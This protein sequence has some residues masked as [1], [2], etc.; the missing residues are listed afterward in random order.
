MGKTVTA[1][2]YRAT[3]VVHDELVEAVK[4]ATDDASVADWLRRRVGAAAISKWNVEFRGTRLSD[5]KK[6]MGDRLYSVYPIARELPD[7]T[8]LAE[9]LDADDL[10]LFPD[11]T[12]R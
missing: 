6:L 12:I 9:L 1:R 2:F 3:G 5:L 11:H 8:T 4:A 10:V 7:D